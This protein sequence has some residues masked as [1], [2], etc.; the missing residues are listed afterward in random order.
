MTLE[1]KI[2]QLIEKFVHSGINAERRT[3][4]LENH[5]VQSNQSL[6]QASKSVSNASQDIQS[7]STQTMR[8]ALKPPV[9]ELEERLKSVRQDLMSAA[10]HVTKQ[11]DQAT[12]KLNRIILFALGAFVLA[13]IVVFGASLYMYKQLDTKIEHTDWISGI[14]AAVAKG[15]LT[16]CTDGGVCALVEK[17]L[18]RLDK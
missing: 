5:F 17:R 1:Q 16:T 13:G 6:A 7:I 8:I 10:N 4:A 18:V 3:K 2:D 9:D 12:Q 11:V 15:K 14:N